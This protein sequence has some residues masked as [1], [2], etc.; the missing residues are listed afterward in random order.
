MTTS[1]VRP[2]RTMA[3]LMQLIAFGRRRSSWRNRQ[4]DLTISTMSGLMTKITPDPYCAA[5]R[6]NHI[7]QNAVARAVASGAGEL[8]T[9]RCSAVSPESAPSSGR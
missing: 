4:S 3:R 2:A 8:T 1:H 5:G 9:D 6:V 7:A